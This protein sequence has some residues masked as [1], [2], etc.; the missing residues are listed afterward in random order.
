MRVI[1]VEWSVL[2]AS[3]ATGRKVFIPRSRER[4]ATGIR[5]GPHHFKRLTLDSALDAT[6]A[7]APH[8]ASRPP[9]LPLQGYIERLRR[10]P[11]NRPK[12]FLLTLPCLPPPG[13]PPVPAGAVIR[14][15]LI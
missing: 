15:H 11:P 3:C 7:R 2:A 8:I 5:A 4:P 1:P 13:N 12:S 10:T 6:A 14:P 9:L